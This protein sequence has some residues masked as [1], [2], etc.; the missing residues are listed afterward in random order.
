MSITVDGEF[1]ENVVELE[2]YLGEHTP[3]SISVKNGRYESTFD[4]LYGDDK[5]ICQYII[6]PVQHGLPRSGNCGI[7]TKDE[8]LEEVRATLQAG[9]RRKANTRK[10]KARKYRSRRNRSRKARH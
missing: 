2:N 4:Y 9:G 6:H 8:V 5:Y 1:L 7:L 3:E 10:Q